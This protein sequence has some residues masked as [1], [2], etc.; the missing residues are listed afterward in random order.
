MGPELLNV[1]I[2]QPSDTTI[3][4]SETEI[5]FDAD[6]SLKEGGSFENDVTINWYYEK[7]GNERVL[8]REQILVIGE[9]TEIVNDN[10]NSSLDGWVDGT[11]YVITVEAETETGGGGPS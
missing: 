10:F 5:T 9:G 4:A 7:N 8:L 6:V 11:T 1:S 2:N 3:D